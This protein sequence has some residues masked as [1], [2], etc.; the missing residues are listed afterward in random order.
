MLY[1][2][3]DSIPTTPRQNIFTVIFAD[4]NEG[5]PKL[6]EIAHFKRCM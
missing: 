3:F 4:R 2:L 5:L 6:E 1:C